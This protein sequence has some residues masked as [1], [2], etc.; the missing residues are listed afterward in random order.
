M[1]GIDQVA[2]N[3]DAGNLRLLNA[4]LAVVMFSI[5]LDLRLDDFRRVARG[6]KPLIVGLTSQFIILPALTFLMIVA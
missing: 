3:F 6:P 1:N 2:L 4:I 5:A